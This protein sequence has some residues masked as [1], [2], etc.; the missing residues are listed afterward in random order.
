MAQNPVATVAAPA[1]TAAVAAPV[2]QLWPR[3]GKAW[4]NTDKKGR[5]F[6]TAVLN[7]TVTCPAG[8]RLALTANNKRE[9][10]RDADYQVRIIL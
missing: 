8:S 1:V 6:I 2:K 7:E 9:G 10:K 5:E 4:I 3:V